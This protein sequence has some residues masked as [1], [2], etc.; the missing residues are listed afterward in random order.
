M[1]TTHDRIEKKV[2]L[3]APRARVWRALADSK[4]F[5]SWFGMELDGPFTAGAK[6][7]GTIVPTKVDPAVA[8]KQKPHE[9][10]AFDI[11]VERVEPE[12][13][14][15]FR[16]HANAIDRSVD[17]SKEP[18]TLVVFEL[19]EHADGVM[20]TMT[21]SGFEGIPLERRA[22]AFTD[23]SEGWALQMMLIEKYLAQAA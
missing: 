10:A 3:R 8:E 5:G 14:L 1:T 4:E 18:M 12:R 19:H 11:S 7:H 9:G 16:W 13:Y 2:L 21:E 20:L 17:Y 6:L 15:S 22:K 23:N